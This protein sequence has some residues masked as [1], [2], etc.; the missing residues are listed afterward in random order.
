MGPKNIKTNFQLMSTT[1][2]VECRNEMFTY[3]ENNCF[4]HKRT[5]ILLMQMFSTVYSSNHA[6]AA[7]KLGELM[8]Y[9]R[10]ER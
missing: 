7:S 6:D 2:G 3:C 10:F 8:H 4:F 9:F 1:G 5:I